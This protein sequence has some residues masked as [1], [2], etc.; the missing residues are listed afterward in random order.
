MIK[1]DYIEQQAIESAMNSNWKDAIVLNKKII[2][3]DKKNLNAY[4]RLGFAYIQTRDIKNAKKAY[5]KAL[6]LQP[7]NHL[8]SNNLERIK[9]LESKKF[10]KKNNAN[11]KFDPNL[12]LEIP[13]K[14]KSVSLVQ[15]GQKNILA[16]ITIGQ[17]VVLKPK[18]RKIEIRTEFED[19]IGSLPDDL[20]KTLYLFIKGGNEYTAYIQDFSLNNVSVFIKETKK[21]K[22]YHKYTSF[23]KDV[24]SDLVQLQMKE[25]HENLSQEHDDDRDPLEDEFESLADNLSTQEEKIYLP[26]SESSEDEEEE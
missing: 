26:Y 1:N 2:K 21:G 15:L 10:K 12:F 17:R 7:K 11:V 19:Y 9:I 8:A 23:T 22:K 4:L 20:S 16:Q 14:T 24:R 25:G 5:T 6:K 18:K 3:T 13:G